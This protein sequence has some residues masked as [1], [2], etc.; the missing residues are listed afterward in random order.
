MT[1]LQQQKDRDVVLKEQI[2][3]LDEHNQKLETFLNDYR[4][5]ILESHRTFKEEI[6]RLDSSFNSHIEEI[7]D[8]MTDLGYKI[9][10]AERAIKQFSE[11]S[12][13]ILELH[14]LDIDRESSHNKNLRA[15]RHHLLGEL[16]SLENHSSEEFHRQSL[17]RL[18]PFE[19]RAEELQDRLTM[20]QQQ[21]KYEREELLDTLQDRLNEKQDAKARYE[22]TDRARNEDIRERTREVE[23]L[24]E[25]L[26]SLEARQA[27][28]KRR[29]KKEKEREQAKA[30]EIERQLA[31][32][33]LYGKA[34]DRKIRE[35]EKQLERK[36]EMHQKQLLRKKGQKK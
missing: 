2:R 13:R 35:I 6:Q 5:F 11:E 31:K 4:K 24:R 14:Q 22:R 30:D 16:H 18:Q 17:L 3:E 33:A 28:R 36:K 9:S 32:Y 8:V 29:E 1:I 34:K 21:I 27:E 15:K 23:E 20:I 25:E 7:D 26:K 19:E 12:A 10:Q